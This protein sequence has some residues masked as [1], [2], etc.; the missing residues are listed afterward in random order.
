MRIVKVKWR[1]SNCQW[2]QHEKDFD[3]KVEVLESVGW[4]LRENDDHVAICQDILIAMETND[5]RGQ[6]VI[7]KENVLSIEVLG[8]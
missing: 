6:T 2:S 8:E 7:P 4:L 5:V 1:D 3:L